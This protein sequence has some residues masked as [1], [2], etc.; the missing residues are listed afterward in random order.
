[1]HVAKVSAGPPSTRALGRILFLPSSGAGHYGDDDSGGGLHRLTS[2]WHSRDPSPQLQTLVILWMASG[3]PREPR[4]ASL[5]QQ[6]SPL[7]SVTLFPLGREVLHSRGQD[8]NLCAKPSLCL[9]HGPFNSHQVCLLI[10]RS[11]WPPD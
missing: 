5:S 2:L 8:T 1:M 4:I 3:P 9:P 6:I 10:I 11:Q 7:P